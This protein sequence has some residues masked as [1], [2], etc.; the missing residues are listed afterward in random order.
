M[1]EGRLDEYLKGD[2]QLEEQDTIMEVGEDE[3]NYELYN[4][5]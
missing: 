4:I 5:V 3:I 1:S 2:I